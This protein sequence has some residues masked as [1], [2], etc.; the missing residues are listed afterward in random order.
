MNF[1]DEQNRAATALAIEARFG[2]RSRRSF[3]PEKTAERATNRASVF[4][5]T[6][7]PK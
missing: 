6:A 1:I 5:P 4:L 2:N 3:T 7:A